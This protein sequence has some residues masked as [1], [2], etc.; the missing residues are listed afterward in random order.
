M[1]SIQRLKTI[2]EFHRTR[3]LT[4]PEH[5]LISIV[6]YA[7][8]QMLPEYNNCQ[9]VFDFY[10]ISL[11]KNIAGKIRYGQQSYDFDEGVMFFIGPGQVFGLERPTEAPSNKSGWMLLIHPDFF[12]NTS[13]A[14]EIK[15]Y[16]Y[17][18]YAIHEA[19]F[20]SK[21]EEDTMIGIIK[22]IEQEYRSNIDK[23]S[24]RIIISQIETLLNYSE[25]FYNRQFITRQ[26][27]GHQLLDKLEELFVAY[28]KDT[29][30][31]NGLPTVQYFA[32]RLNVSPKYLSNMLKAL[33]GQTA[34]QL[35]HEQLIELA[36]Q[37]LSITNL[38]VSEIAYELGF[39]HSQSFSKLFKSKTNLSPLEF[40][41]SFHP[42]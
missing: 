30:P 38:T 2:S 10:F 18:G 28:F 26:R 9:W 3:G 31:S 39:E 12:W 20:V 23:F 36:K 41:K 35:I 24:Q 5:P 42:N 37:K 19:L 16:E 17:F 14:K 27:A 40:R 25:R 7:E 29:E 13:L 8:V 21:K 34:Q 15:K 32:D 22:T 33:T 11:K 4:P 6:N 1:A